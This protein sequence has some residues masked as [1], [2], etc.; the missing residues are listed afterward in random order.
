MKM[1]KFTLIELLVVVAI[2]GI[3]AAML[4]PALASVREKANIAKCKSYLKQHG[5]S[6][7][8]YFNAD[9]FQVAPVYSGTLTAGD[10]VDTALNL[11]DNMLACSAIN[12]SGSNSIFF[13]SPS[14]T[15]GHNANISGQRYGVINNPDSIIMEDDVAHKNTGKVSQMRGDGHVEES[16]D[17]N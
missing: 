2:I 3:L 14:S 1:T 7:G 5:I 11:D 4:L 15:V 16:A 13:Y 8:A 12:L 17:S 6:F 10:L 9:S